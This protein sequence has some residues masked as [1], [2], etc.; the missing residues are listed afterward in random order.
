MIPNDA[1]MRTEEFA[2]EEA[3]WLAFEQRQDLIETKA[4]ELMKQ[5][6]ECYPW[7]HDRILEAIAQTDSTVL[8]DYIRVAILQPDNFFSQAQV[9]GA[10]HG[11]IEAYWLEVAK[12]VA[13]KEMRGE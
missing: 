8:T 1:L 11:I 4:K 5:G 6:G 12:S 9:V 7:Q 13:E 3:K 2:Q 10:I